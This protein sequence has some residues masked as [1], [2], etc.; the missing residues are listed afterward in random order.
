MRGY[1]SSQQLMDHMRVVRSE[2]QSSCRQC[3]K[4]WAPSSQGGCERAF[5]AK[6]HGEWVC[7]GCWFVLRGNQMQITTFSM[8]P[9]YQFPFI[10]KLETCCRWL[11]TKW[12]QGC[13]AA[14]F[15]EGG[16]MFTTTLTR[17]SCRLLGVFVRLPVA[18]SDGTVCETDKFSLES[19]WRQRW[20][21]GRECKWTTSCLLP[22]C[23]RTVC[24]W[25]W[26]GG[27]AAAEGSK[28]TKR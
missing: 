26:R 15:R 1:K 19:F 9:S 14:C 24:D 27:Q 3:E 10:K 2:G 21:A 20:G 4:T 12:G 6:R 11:D 16:G 13:L 28:S 7:G 25:G 23:L 18:A 8:G 5:I 17:G 22:C